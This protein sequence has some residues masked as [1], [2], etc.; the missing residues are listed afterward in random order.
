MVI[1]NLTSLASMPK[2]LVHDYFNSHKLGPLNKNSYEESMRY[3][4]SIFLLLSILSHLAYSQDILIKTNGEEISFKKI[5]L[6]DDFVEIVKEDREKLKVNHDEIVGYYED[7]S[8]KIYYKQPIV[9]DNERR[10]EIFKT[11]KDNGYEYLEREET[12]KINLY[13]RVVT[14]MTPGHMGP[15]GTMSAGTSSSTTYYYAEDDDQY[16]N[17]YITGLLQDKSDDIKA[18]EDF[19]SDDADILKKLKSDDFRLNE[20][21]LLSLIR[22]YNLRN[23]DK[24]KASE[25]SSKGNV[26]FYSRV[27]PKLK[28]KLTVTI[29]DSLV[30]KLPASGMPLPVGLPKN[31]PSKVCVSWESGSHCKIMNPSPYSIHYYE[32][33]YFVGD[34]SFEIRHKTLSEF[35]NY[36]LSVIK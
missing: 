25:Y 4:K 35:K 15:G 12:G 11:R 26:S 18:L 23:F 29:N 36:M 30:H 3:M 10:L 2:K 9:P 27:R 21:N 28:E 17:V 24:V 14:S 33:D 16:G 8:Q 13:K 5:K 19:V 34:K 20:K 7:H 32:L 31:V 1:L 6:Q 22:E